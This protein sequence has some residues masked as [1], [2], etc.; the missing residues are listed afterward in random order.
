MSALFSEKS[1]QH[2]HSE[3]N[4]SEFQDNLEVMFSRFRMLAI[5]KGLTVPV[6]KELI[7][8]LIHT[9]YCL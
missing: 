3:T 6:P 5:T 9:N 1:L 8:S 7:L 4:A 2:S